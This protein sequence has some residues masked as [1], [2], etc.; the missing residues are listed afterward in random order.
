MTPSNY[1]SKPTN[2]RTSSNKSIQKTSNGTDEYANLH[3]YQH[4]DVN[5][6]IMKTTSNREVD[7]SLNNSRADSKGSKRKIFSR[8]K[9][10]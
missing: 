9:I 5:S 2:L 8:P 4:L 7:S 6:K 10:E 3:Y 1:F